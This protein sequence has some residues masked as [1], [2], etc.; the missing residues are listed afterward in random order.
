M[1][2]T[3]EIVTNTKS[4]LLGLTP[5]QAERLDKIF[6]IPVPG[7]QFSPAFKA[8]LWDGT[9][10]FFSRKTCLFGT[11]LLHRVKKV[12][13]SVCETEITVV[14]RR[15]HLAKPYDPTRLSLQMLKGIESLYDYQL[16]AITASLEAERCIVWIATGGGKSLVAAGCVAAFPEL[17]VTL[18]LVHKKPLM[19]QAMGDLAKFLGLQDFHIGS[20]GDGVFSP[21]KITVATVQ[22]LFRHLKESR[23]ATFLASVEFLVLDECHHYSNKGMFSKVCAAIDAPRRLALSGTPFPDKISKIPVEASCGPVVTKISN[24]ALIKKGV[25]AKPTVFFVNYEAPEMDSNIR[26]WF[27]LYQPGIVNCP[28]RNIAIAETIARE[29]AAGRQVLVLLT[30]IVHGDMLSSM[31]SVKDIKHVFVT[32]KLGQAI[33]DLKVKFEQRK[34]KVIIATTVFDEGLNI[35]GVE[36]LVIAD[37][38]KSLRKFLQEFGRGLRKKKRGANEVRVFDFLDNHHRI[39]AKHSLRRLEICEQEKFEVKIA[40]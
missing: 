16:D 15:A 32:G 25:N 1:G 29:V 19:R 31:L 9:R 13:G 12:A 33:D 18:Y 7:S 37:A 20:I 5:S 28:E 30:Q 21:R 23:V 22:S 39:L 36:S 34:A 27:S 11:G 6:S 14:D 38:G 40:S 35:E 3:L 4:R 17:P 10:H 26:E 24:D 8:K 2:V